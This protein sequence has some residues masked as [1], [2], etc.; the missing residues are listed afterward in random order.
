MV[1]SAYLG[2]DENGLPVLPVKSGEDGRYHLLG[3]LQL[4]PTAAF[5]TNVKQVEI[6]LE[7]GGGAKVI[8]KVPVPR[9]VRST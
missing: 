1:N 9:Y 3:D 2:T 8:I 4:A 5:K 6:L 7:Q